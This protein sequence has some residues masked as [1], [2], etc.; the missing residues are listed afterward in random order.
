MSPPENIISTRQ[1]NLATN[2]MHQPLA[3]EQYD[4]FKQ[5]LFD[6][7]EQRLW[8][9]KKVYGTAKM[10][11]VLGSIKYLLPDDKDWA[12]RSQ[13]IFMELEERL[14]QDKVD[15]ERQKNLLMDKL[16]SLLEEVAHKPGTVGQIVAQQNILGN[17]EELK[18]L[19]Q[20]KDV[21][22]LLTQLI[23]AS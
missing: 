8:V 19:L 20:N 12:L 6:K 9:I 18:G 11:E 13:E 3:P 7:F 1:G 15:Q 22:Q 10:E 4:A 2:E 14:Q 5:Q 16:M 17:A 23:S 21:K